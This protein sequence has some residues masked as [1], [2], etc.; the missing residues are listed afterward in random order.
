MRVIEL[1]KIEREEGELFYRKKY[2]CDAVLE[3]PTSND[4]VPIIFTVETDPFSRKIIEIT[5]LSQVNYPLVS[6]KKVLKEYILT[7]EL[8]GRLPC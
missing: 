2:K 3:L 1:Q 8:E 4:V 5:F 7:E 6:V